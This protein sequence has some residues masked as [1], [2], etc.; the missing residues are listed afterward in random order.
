MKNKGCL[1]WLIIGWWWEP[2]YWICFGWLKL[3][4][5]KNVLKFFFTV[6]YYIVIA[7]LFLAVIV[8]LIPI[9]IVLFIFYLIYIII[10]S[11]IDRQSY[12]EN[13]KK[14]TKLYILKYIKQKYSAFNIKKEKFISKFIS[15]FKIKENNNIKHE[16]L[17]IKDENSVETEEINQDTELQNITDEEIIESFKKQ[18]YILEE[19]KEDKI[20]FKF[21]IDQKD[22]E[23]EKIV[24][25]IPIEKE[26]AKRKVISHINPVSHSMSSYELERFMVECNA[27]VIKKERKEEYNEKKEF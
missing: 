19:D 21:E 25:N 7:A 20:S 3:L 14:Y 12:N 18:Y 22:S 17:L 9:F 24:E 27:Y 4:F 15:L 10:K 1:Y 11:I 6:I 8:L 5:N 13:K 16:E 23:E 26:E 2:F